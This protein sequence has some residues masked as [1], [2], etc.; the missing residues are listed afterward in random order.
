MPPASRVDRLHVRCTTNRHDD[1]RALRLRRRLAATARVH[2][3]AALAPI[4]AAGERRVFAERLTVRLD[5]DPDEYDDV[6]LAALWA[7]HVERALAELAER[8]G[9]RV[10]ETDRDFWAAAG[11]EWADTGGLTWEFEELGCGTGARLPA[12]AV[13]AAFDSRERVA[14]L[15]VALA[16]E[17]ARARAAR[18]RLAPREQSLVRAALAGRLS[19]G[20]WGADAG[21]VG[22]AGPGAGDALADERRRLRAAFDGPPPQEAEGA[23]GRGGGGGG[24]PPRGGSA[25]DPSAWV[26]AWQ[27]CAASGAS[28]VRF[29]GPAP[30]QAE[31]AESLETAGSARDRGGGAGGP[32]PPAPA[33]KRRRPGAR[34]GKPESPGFGAEARELTESTAWLTRFGGLVLLYPW[35]AGHLEADL[36]VAAA[37][38]GLD[39]EAGARMWALAALAGPEPAPAAVLDPLVRALAGDDPGRELGGWRPDPPE[40]LAAL[41]PAADDLVRRFAGALPGFEGSSPAYLRREFLVRDGLLEPAPTGG[42]AVTL[43]PAPLDLAL[44]RL[45]YPLLP[46]SLPWTVAFEPAIRGRGA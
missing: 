4:A 44:E 1:H 2:L 43:E 42:L 12:L 28:R 36:P 33:P 22:V 39:P 29:D 40:E 5:F 26:A 35:L 13:L 31:L 20:R 8:D 16:R 10:F 11:A 32:R 41:A 24:P 9:A 23:P 21:G 25:A 27:E 14:A 37:P 3:P 30:A 19:W 6:T 45:S 17:P 15:A 18:A 34:A 38:P 46:F 7:A